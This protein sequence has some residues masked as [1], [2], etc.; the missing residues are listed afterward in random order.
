MV[1][2]YNEREEELGDELMRAL[3]RFMLL[4]I[5]DE[6]WR[7]HLHDMDYLREGI[8]LPRLRPDRSAGGL[9]ER[10]LR[11]VHGAHEQRLGRVRSLHLQRRGRGRGGAAARA[12]VVDGR[13]QHQLLQLRGRPRRRRKAAIAAAAGEADELP[14]GVADAADLAAGEVLAQPIETKRLDEHEKIGRNDPRCAACGRRQCHG[15]VA[16]APSATS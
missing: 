5:I 14:E 16:Q 12:A 6:R 10:G 15:G 1:D 7:E 2:A 13:Q 9:Q 4:Q 3:E 8:H 11:D